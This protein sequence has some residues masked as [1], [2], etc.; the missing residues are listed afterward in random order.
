VVPDLLDQVGQSD[1]EAQLVLQGCWVH[2]D[3][4]EIQDQLDHRV[5]KELLDL[6]VV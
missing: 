4:Q 3:L 1:L 2:Q 6:K 5:R